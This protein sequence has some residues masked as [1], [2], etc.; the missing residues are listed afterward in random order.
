M[1]IVLEIQYIA[2]ETETKVSQKGSFPAKGEAP[3]TIAFKWWRQI[4]KEM[5][6]EVAIE[7]VFADGQDITPLVKNIEKKRIHFE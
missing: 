4:K 6:V 1:N 2:T 7:K 3:E 5:R